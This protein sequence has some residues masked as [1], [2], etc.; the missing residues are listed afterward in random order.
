MKAIH[1]LF[2]VV[3]AA[4]LLLVLIVGTASAGHRP[5]APVGK[6]LRPDSGRGAT[7]ST[8]VIPACVTRASFWNLSFSSQPA[9]RTFDMNPLYKCGTGL[10]GY[11]HLINS[12]SYDC[13]FTIT[14]HLRDNVFKA[15][16]TLDS[17]PRG[18]CATDL[19]YVLNGTLR[20]GAGTGSGTVR[21]NHRYSGTWGAA[22]FFPA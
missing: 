20:I 12:G 10:T 11:A 9:G 21:N 4:A 8:H 16:W 6:H 18:V 14:G 5:A 7:S 13:E 19:T 2:V 17:N 15:T 3:P 1:R 22:R